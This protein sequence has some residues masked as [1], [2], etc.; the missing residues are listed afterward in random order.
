M[1]NVIEREHD[2]D[3]EH[4]AHRTE[5]G[6][7]MCGL[8]GGW[9]WYNGQ[10][11]HD[12]RRL[13]ARICYAC[14]LAE[15]LIEGKNQHKWLREGGRPPSWNARY[16]HDKLRGWGYH[17]SELPLAHE[18]TP[19]KYIGLRDAIRAPNQAS[20]RAQSPSAWSGPGGTFLRADPPIIWD[21]ATFPPA[22]RQTIRRPRIGAGQQLPDAIEQQQEVNRL[23]E[24][25]YEMEM[26]WS[27]ASLQWQVHTRTPTG[28]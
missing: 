8:R 6:K 17:S 7:T 12:A 4:L 13:A 23:N 2:I 14:A 26:R 25:N 10:E 19:S 22:N 5:P 28:R 18:L 16:A 1:F 20:T 27:D 3:R 11:F 15:P 24:L 9:P 21:G